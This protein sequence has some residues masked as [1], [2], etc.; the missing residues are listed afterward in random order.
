MRV[1]D[2]NCDMGESFGRYSL[3]FDEEIMDYVTSANI[4]CGFH[5]GDPSVMDATVAMAGKRG[6]GI[7]AHP[8][9]PDLQGFGRRSMAMSAKELR[10]SLIYQIGAL[11]G[12]TDFYGY[13]LQHVKLHGALYNMAC[14][15]SVLAKTV[16]ESVAVMDRNLIFVALYG[17]ELYRAG[18]DMGL[19]VAGEFFADRHYGAD[20]KLLPRTHADAL[21]TGD[22]AVLDRCLLAV[23]EGKV[24][25]VDGTVLA[26]EVDTICLHGDNPAALR[27]A[28]LIRQDL[29]K[30]GLEVRPLASFL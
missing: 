27:L 14:A 20:G 12:F 6:L 18:I 26:V 16:A 2:L 9:Y 1:I 29:E 5:A 25:A 13:R 21:V 17:S 15:D 4:A 7:G 10:A 30:H 23:K 28:R 3:G 19:K 22:Q 11:K 24:E 8:S